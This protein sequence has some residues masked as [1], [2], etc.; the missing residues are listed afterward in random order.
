MAVTIDDVR[1]ILGEINQELLPDTVVQAMI[2]DATSF[3]SSKIS[4][5]N[6]LFDMAVKWYAAYYSILAYSEIVRRRMGNQPLAQE[7][8]LR[9]YE[10]IA[11]EILSAAIAAEGAEIMTTESYPVVEVTTSWLDEEDP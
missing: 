9:R 11:Q 3:V 10:R 1:S 5:T 8:P 4:A 7:I 6:S 2:D